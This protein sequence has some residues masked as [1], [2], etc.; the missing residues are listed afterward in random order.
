MSNAIESFELFVS[1]TAHVGPILV[2]SLGSFQVAEPAR[3]RF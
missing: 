2:H 3:V 1:D